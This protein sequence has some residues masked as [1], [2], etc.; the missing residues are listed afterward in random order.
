[1]ERQSTRVADQLWNSW[2]VTR[3]ELGGPL[4]MALRRHPARTGNKASTQSI[5]RS[6]HLA[7]A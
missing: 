5:A 2:R 7:P 4:P 6:A 1:M 3:L